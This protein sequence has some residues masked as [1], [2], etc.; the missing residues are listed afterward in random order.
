MFIEDKADGFVE[1]EDKDGNLFQTENEEAKA[2]KKA[3]KGSSDPAAPIPGS[4][5]NGKLYQ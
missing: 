3:K 1:F 4:F 5:I 2:V